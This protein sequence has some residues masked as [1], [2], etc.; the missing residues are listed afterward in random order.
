MLSILLQVLPFLLLFIIYLMEIL[1]QQAF[2]QHFS[3]V[4]VL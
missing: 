3:A 1:Q 4:V 2:G